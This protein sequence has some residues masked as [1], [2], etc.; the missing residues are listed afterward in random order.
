MASKS[1]IPC[2]HYNFFL[3][4]NLSSELNILSKLELNLSHPYD[5]QKLHKATY[6]RSFPDH[7]SYPVALVEERVVNCGEPGILKEEATL[8]AL[9]FQGGV[10]LPLK[11]LDGGE[12][13]AALEESWR[14]SENLSNREQSLSF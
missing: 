7:A 10:V 14:H 5:F 6:P 4:S 12:H 11:G 2:T 8:Q 9:P 13:P 1:P 3:C